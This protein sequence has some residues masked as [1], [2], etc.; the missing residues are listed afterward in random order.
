MKKLILKNDLIKIIQIYKFLN[1]IAVY[2]SASTRAF[3][4]FSRDIKH[5][6]KVRQ[7]SFRDKR[8]SGGNEITCL[9]Q[10]QTNPTKSTNR[11]LQHPIFCLYVNSILWTQDSRL[12]KII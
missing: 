7:G 8:V 3:A 5:F 1:T 2:F 10:K 4:Q 6:F 11:K 9:A 12:F